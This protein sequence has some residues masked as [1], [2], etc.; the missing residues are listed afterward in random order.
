VRDG[1]QRFALSFGEYADDESRDVRETAFSYGQQFDGG[2]AIT[3]TLLRREKSG[4]RPAEGV[5]VD[6][7]YRYLVFSFGGNLTVA[8]QQGELR[9]SANVWVIADA[10][11]LEHDVN[12]ALLER[13]REDFHATDIAVT[14]SWTAGRVRPSAKLEF[15]N[16][17]NAAP[18]DDDA[19][20]R[21]RAIRLSAGVRFGLD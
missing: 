21:P 11:L 2:T 19:D 15:E 5:M 14:Y 18:R 7:V 8:K 12:V 4:E 20:Q 9:D 1:M 16:L 3:A 6:A 17:F 13:L 10:P